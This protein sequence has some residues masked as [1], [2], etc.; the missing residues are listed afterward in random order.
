[1]T[2][3]PAA[4]TV[5]VRGG[6]SIQAEPERLLSYAG[7]LDRAGQQVTGDLTVLLGGLPRT[8]A[9]MAAAALDPAGAAEVGML[10][11]TSMMG[12]IALGASCRSMAASLRL[13]AAGYAAADRFDARLA[14]VA[15]AV[16][17]L[18]PAVG[19]LAGGHPEQA[20]TSD[21]ELA[22]LA[23]DGL[24]LVG[25]AALGRFRPV[26]AGLAMAAPRRPAT[27]SLAGALARPYRDGTPRVRRRGLP[28][29]D[30][31]GPPRTLT[32]LMADV[33]LRELHD[34]GGG[35][36]DIRLLDGPD[37]RRVI[38]DITGTTEWNVDPRHPTPQATDFGTNLRSLADEPSVM[39]RGV[40]QALRTAGVRPTEPI[41]LVGHSQGGMVAAEL[42]DELNRTGGYR[43]THVLTAGS[44]VGLARLPDSV[45]VL[46]LENCG[47]LVPQLDGSD[48]PAARNWVTARVSRGGTG[49]TGRHSISSYQ[50]AAGDLDRSANPALT[51]WR[52]GAAGYLHADRVRTEVFQVSRN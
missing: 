11:G 41:M 9:L 6:S 27:A 34:R 4:G 29:L 46:S 21:P 22:D 14:P 47:D 42:A 8:P 48:N 45:S 23:I 13:A 15:R 36:V 37:G 35:A 52:T 20:L 43:V 5:A 38:V 2:G 1:M 19:A 24:G 3:A 30:Q 25:G 26:D 18:G 16:R 39:S 50:A 31:A 7:Q 12:A 28:T 51:S 49:I 33:A 10:C 17:Q 40:Q 44:P 32:D